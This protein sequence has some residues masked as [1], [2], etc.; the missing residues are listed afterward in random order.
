MNLRARK[1]NV[2]IICLSYSIFLVY[3]HFFSI[4]KQHFI[5]LVIRNFYCLFT[6][7]WAESMNFRVK[8]YDDLFVILS[9]R[10]TFFD[11][12]H[13]SKTDYVNWSFFAEIFK[14]QT[15]KRR[16]MI[17]FWRKKLFFSR[18]IISFHDKNR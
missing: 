11:T 4:T 15:H 8:T 12:A 13:N 5:L 18:K 14:R 7:M 6:C 17:Y 2:F 9:I 16:K 10:E 1:I 3:C